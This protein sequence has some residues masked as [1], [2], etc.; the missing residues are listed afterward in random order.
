MCWPFYMSRVARKGPVVPPIGETLDSE[1]Y[2]LV[3]LLISFSLALF[4]Q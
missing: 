2:Q 3:T 1:P 4:T